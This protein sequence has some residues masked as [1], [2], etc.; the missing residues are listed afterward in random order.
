[1]VRN[2]RFRTVASIVFAALLVSSAVAPPALADDGEESFFDGLVDDESGVGLDQKIATTIS[3]ATSWASRTSATLFNDE[4]GNATKYAEEF[5]SEFESANETTVDYANARVNATSGRDV[6]RL[7]FHD[8]DGGNTTRYLVADVDGDDWANAH[9]VESVPMNR[10]VDHYVEFDWY[11]SKH[12]AEEF[13]TF[14]SEYA[15]SGGDLSAGYRATLL[16]KYGAPDS[17]LWNATEESK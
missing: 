15:R 12:A 2:S 11:Q 14:V 9:V 13:E 1:M 17:D 5:E 4:S 7:S 10:Q 6:F 3:S 16:G 8:R